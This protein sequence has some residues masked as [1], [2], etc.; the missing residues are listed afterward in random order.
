MHQRQHNTW[1]SFFF[2]SKILSTWVSHFNLA[3]FFLFFFVFFC[4]SFL[5][6]LPGMLQQTASFMSAK[7]H[8]VH[9][10]PCHG[11]GSLAPIMPLC[12]PSLPSPACLSVW[13]NLV[14][15]VENWAVLLNQWE[16]NPDPDFTGL[17]L[18]ELRS[19]VCN[20][21][22]MLYIIFIVGHGDLNYKE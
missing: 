22:P 1:L 14:F 9:P 15:T 10:M 5:I 16:E 17:K 4:L 8:L 3:C 13:E 6:L 21:L 20:S 11:T 7:K 2:F 18:S 12:F 19:W